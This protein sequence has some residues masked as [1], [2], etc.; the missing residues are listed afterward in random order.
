MRYLRSFWCLL[1]SSM[2]FAAAE[3]PVA[4]VKKRIPRPEG[5]AIGGPLPR[6]VFLTQIALNNKRDR[7][8]T[9]KQYYLYDAATPET[10]FRKVY[11]GPGGDFEQY[12]QFVTPLFGGVG[13]A[14]GRID[15]TS[16][17]S[18]DR[19]F[20][21]DLFGDG[22]METI[23]EKPWK[24]RMV[25]NEFRYRASDGY[26]HCFNFLDGT[27][28]SFPGHLSWIGE[29]LLVGVEKVDE[30][31]HVVMVD[32]L[33]S[34]K[35][36]LGRVPPSCDRS[37]RRW[38]RPAIFP[39]GPEA[40]DGIFIEDYNEYSVWYKA[41]KC[42]W[43]RVV[44]NI[45]VVDNPWTSRSDIWLPI[46]YVGDRRFAV[47]GYVWSEGDSGKFVTMLV[48]GMTGRVVEESKNR[49]IDYM[50]SLEIPERWWSEDLA[51]ISKSRE[52]A[53]KGK[54]PFEWVEKEKSYRYAKDK[55]L[56]ISE[57]QKASLSQD[58]RYLMVYQP[59]A[60]GYWPRVE[61]K[62]TLIDGISGERRHITLPIRAE[63]A[64]VDRVAWLIL[65]SSSPDPAVMQ[66]F[67]PP[68]PY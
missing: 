57:D 54:R 32:A 11:E 39:A 4:I 30:A 12:C 19:L 37:W 21:F 3:S 45:S 60:K 20:W 48:E 52:D 41:P 18:R 62:F 59:K 5:H 42:R 25:G 23:A 36:D 49:K 33:K 38:P 22:P 46:A 64:E 44:K 31:L 24:E 47:G 53:R 40:R 34:I 63:R 65:C 6:P 10:G 7:A 26:N 61:H 28:R 1:L 27:V 51:R 35:I 14:S 67:R 56:K 13:L 43:L 2:A 29:N 66:A 55:Q 9:K 16:R 50:S 15:P 17:V 58:G 8:D 68:A